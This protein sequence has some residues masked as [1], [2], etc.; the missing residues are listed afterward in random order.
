MLLLIC[1][2]LWEERWRNDCASLVLCNTENF[3]LFTSSFSVVQKEAALVPA[4]PQTSYSFQFCRLSVFPRGGKS[5]FVYRSSSFLSLFCSDFF[6]AMSPSIFNLLAGFHFLS[7]LQWR[8]FVRKTPL[9]TD[10]SLFP[11]PYPPFFF[12]VSYFFVSCF[13]GNFLS[14]LITSRLLAALLWVVITVLLG[15]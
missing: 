15:V 9:Y 5:P 7:V 6:Q 13:L 8:R 2:C 4:G 11:T 10:T 14:S 12:P 1:Q 3:S